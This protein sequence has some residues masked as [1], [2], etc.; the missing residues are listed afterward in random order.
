[1]SPRNQRNLA[2]LIVGSAALVIFVRLGAPFLSSDPGADG[3]PIAGS[4]LAVESLNSPSRKEALVR[5]PAGDT[6]RA[7]IPADCLV[8]AGQTAYMR[9]S[10]AALA[11]GPRFIVWRTEDKK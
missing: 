10:R 2:W 9:P 6:V 5:L 8:F 1:M 3:R 4:V 11:S 7:S